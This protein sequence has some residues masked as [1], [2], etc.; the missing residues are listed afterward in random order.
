MQHGS[1]RLSIESM[2][3]TWALPRCRAQK[4]I[5]ATRRYSASGRAARRAEFRMRSVRSARADMSVAKKYSPWRSLLPTYW[6]P[7]IES[8]VDAGRRSAAQ[9]AATT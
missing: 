5:F 8:V 2:D 1:Q 7:L 3:I 4:R 9:Q 6:E